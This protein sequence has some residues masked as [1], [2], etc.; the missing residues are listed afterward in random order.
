MEDLSNSI[1][2]DQSSIKVIRQLLWGERA[3][4]LSG[5]DNILI[6]HK[7]KI[8]E[9]NELMNGSLIFSLEK[10]KRSAPV[11]DAMIF[12]V[13]GLD[14]NMFDEALR[15]MELCVEEGL[16]F[17]NLD[18]PDVLEQLKETPADWLI[19]TF[20]EGAENRHAIKKYEQKSSLNMDAL[21]DFK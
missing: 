14:S 15:F 8:R 18:I 3:T 16:S 4:S 9:I 11:Y 17:M 13:Q 10:F 20:T 2:F 19:H 12:L 5:K 6:S 7:E 21:R 1:F